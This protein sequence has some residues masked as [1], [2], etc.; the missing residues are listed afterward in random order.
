MAIDPSIIL[1]AGQSYQPIQAPD[2][3]DRYAKLMAIQGGMGQQ[4]LQGLQLEKGRSDLDADKRLRAL[5]TSNP[6]ATAEQVMAIDP[7]KGIQFGKAQIEQKQAAA[8]L[9]KT[10]NELVVQA[11][12]RHRDDLANVNDPQTA[13][14]WIMSGYADPRLKPILERNGSPEDAIARIP[15]D[16]TAFQ[17]WKQ[18]NALGATKFIELN[19]PTVHNVD[20]GGSII[21]KLYPGLGGP[22]TVAGTTAKTM[23]PGEVQSGNIQRAQLGETRRHNTQT[24][25][26]ARDTAAR[27]KLQ[28]VTD[29][30][31]NIT[32]VD[33]NTR[34]G[35]PAVDSQGNVLKGRQNLTESQGKAAGLAMR[36]TEANKILNDLEGQGVTTRGIMKQGVEAVPFVGEGLGMAVNALPGVMGGPS[37]DQ[38]KVEQAQR[39]F[40]NAILRVES[41]ASINESEFR[42]AAKQYFPQPGDTPQVIE[43]KRQGRADSI[44]ALQMQAGPPRNPAGADPAK[45]SDAELKRELGIP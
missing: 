8:G 11:T 33:K 26:N 14:Q 16:P 34:V 6:N 40:V 41:G 2:P 3:M 44:K 38:Q 29:T 35:K 9:E 20:T 45:L 19:K 13:A 31:G 30:D 12:A 25:A 23:T 5:F 42:N 36:A 37:A 43:Q 1:R 7:M 32:V 22:A 24:E 21:E 28:I 17:Q 15:Q 27:D 10:N 39:N 4:E 18:Q